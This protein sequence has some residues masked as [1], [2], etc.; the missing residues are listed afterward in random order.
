[1]L[2]NLEFSTLAHWSGYATMFFA[3][4]TVVAWLLK[5]GV[6]FRLVGVTGFMTVLT[7]GLFTLTLSLYDRPTIPGAVR[8]NRVYDM[9]STEVVIV[10]PAQISES[11][12]EATL[13]QAAADLFS[14]GRLSRGDGKMTIRARALLHPQAGVSQP[15]YLGQIRRS[16]AVRNDDHMEI[17]IFRDQLAKL[18]QSAA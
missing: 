14:P 4:L 18:P 15:V 17:Q 10:V 8:F 12:L 13:Q 16:L 11:Q 7:A 2:A 3:V 9:G 1:M 6:R 5:W